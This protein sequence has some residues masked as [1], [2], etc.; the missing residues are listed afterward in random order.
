MAL[1]SYGAVRHGQGKPQDCPFRYQGQYEDVETGLYYN[2]LRYFDPETGNYIRV[3]S[4]ML[5]HYQS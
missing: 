3:T 4:A 5:L 2:R 1:N